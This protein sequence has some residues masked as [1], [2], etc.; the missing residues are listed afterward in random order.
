MVDC[1][2]SLGMSPGSERTPT[3][4]AEVKP[5]QGLVIQP[6]PLEN[7]LLIFLGSRRASRGTTD[8]EERG[9]GTGEREVDLVDNCISGGRLF[10]SVLRRVNYVPRLT[11]SWLLCGVIV[12]IVS[13]SVNSS[14]CVFE[15]LI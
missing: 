3:C 12:V 13:K 11:G 8:T 9:E 15:V 6:N 14:L 5:H 1:I 4:R 7:L 2:R 10:V